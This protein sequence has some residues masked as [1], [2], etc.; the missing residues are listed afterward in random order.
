MKPPTD[1]GQPVTLDIEDIFVFPASLTTAILRWF[2]HHWRRGTYQAG[3]DDLAGEQG[4]GDQRVQHGSS[5]QEA[6]GQFQFWQHFFA[7][8]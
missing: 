6:Q 7:K 1:P 2:C 4:G 8:S 5:L 3:D